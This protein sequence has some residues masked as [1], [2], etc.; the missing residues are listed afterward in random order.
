MTNDD[1]ARG[2]RFQQWPQIFNMDVLANLGAIAVFIFKERAFSDHHLCL[3]ELLAK[4]EVADF[5]ISGVGNQWNLDRLGDFNTLTTQFTQA[6]LR[7]TTEF[8]T[9]LTTAFNH[10]KR[11]RGGG[12]TD[13]NGTN[14]HIRP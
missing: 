11:Q 12:V 10:Y 9:Q 3:T 13:F 7:D 5:R 2:P 6:L 14:K 4:Q 1:V 8:F